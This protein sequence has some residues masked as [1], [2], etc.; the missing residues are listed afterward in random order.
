L[1]KHLE[2]VIATDCDPIRAENQNDGWAVKIKRWAAYQIVR[3]GLKIVALF[4][5]Y[6][7]FKNL[8]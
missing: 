6:H 1:K 5:N 3:T 7:P 4:P 2:E 8:E